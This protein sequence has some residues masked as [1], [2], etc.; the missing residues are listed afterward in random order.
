VHGGCDRTRCVRGLSLLS[1]A[2][3]T[4]DAGAGCVT[5]PPATT[6]PGAGR[7]PAQELAPEP[8]TVRA[9]P[10]EA[11]DGLI[12]D[13]LTQ[14]ANP[15]YELPPSCLQFPNLGVL[16]RA[17]LFPSAPKE[18]ATIVSEGPYAATSLVPRLMNPIIADKSTAPTKP[19]ASGSKKSRAPA[20]KREH[21][22]TTDPKCV[23]MIYWLH[24]V[25]AYGYI[26]ESSSRSS[27]CHNTS[28]QTCIF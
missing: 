28:R 11:E 24:N 8:R 2:Q 20:M 23:N 25:F 3:P 5:I 6:L 7:V 14:A 22:G 26:S 13:Y 17:G 18:A 12:V 10:R 21:P 19:A 27:G 15:L 4:L 9:L 1:F 16:S